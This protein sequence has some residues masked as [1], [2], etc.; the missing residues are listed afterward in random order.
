MR[1]VFSLVF[2]FFVL[3]CSAQVQINGVVDNGEKKIEGAVI[4]V[5]N[6]QQDIL[7]YNI[8]GKDGNFSIALNARAD[9]LLLVVSLLG[10]ETKA[11][12]V[13]YKNQFLQV[14]LEPKSIELKEVSIKS[15][16]IWKREDTLVYSVDAFKY[17]Q[18]R[19]IGDILKKLPG[20]EVSTSG[21]IKYNGEAINKFYIE[22]LDLL[23][24][25][26]GIATNNVP[27]DAVQNIEVIENHQPVN[28]LKNIFDTGQA[29]INLKLKNSKMVHPVGTVEAGIGTDQ[30]G[31]LWLF[32]AFALQ[33]GKK[34]QTIVMYKTNNAAI[35]IAGEM[36]GHSTD[37]SSIDKTSVKQIFS[38]SSFSEMSL[39][40]KRYLF[41]NTHVATINNVWKVS[42][43]EQ[44]RVNINYMHNERNENVYKRNTYYINS[45]SLFVIDESSRLNRVSNILDGAFTY[46]NNSDKFYLDDRLNTRLLWNKTVSDISSFNRITEHYSTPVYELSN[47][48]QFIKRNNTRIWDITSNIYYSSLPQRLAVTVD[49]LS[50]ELLQPVHYTGL[51]TNNSTYISFSKG[52]SNLL[53]R[54]R[55]EGLFEGLGSDLTHNYLTDSI[56]N[57]LK[58]DFV[59]LALDPEYTFRKDRIKLMFNAGIKQQWLG[60]KDRQYGK[61]KFFS[62][63]YILPRIN[64]NYKFNPFLEGIISYRF[65]K[66]IGD[67]FDFT[68]SVIMY[69]YRNI[70]IKSGI[71]SKRENQSFNIRI[72]YRNPINRL[73]FNT[74]VGYMHTKRNLLGKQSFVDIQSV[75]GNVEGNNSLDTWLWMLYAGKYAS[76]IRT[77]FSI[78]SNY[79]YSQSEKVQQGIRYPVRSY[80]LQ[81]SPMFNTKLSENMNVAYQFD[82]NTNKIKIVSKTGI[83]ESESNQLSHTLKY[84][85]FIKK[86]ELNIQLEHLYNKISKDI[87]TNTFFADI[88]IKLATKKVDFLLAWNN[89]FNKKEY[90]YIVYSSLDSYIYNFP[91]RPSNIL[92]T[93]AFK[94]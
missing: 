92:V 35:N 68:S 4:S 18:D 84:F 52:Y 94:Y 30:D 33:A 67:I 73:F 22:G 50:N 58:S 2:C 57:D 61:N 15:D 14:Q 88:N 19:T 82:F 24:N 90:K 91:L 41:N 54:F 69:N 65:N 37:L 7:D 9:S 47:K 49:T 72:N 10:Y 70:G 51:Y 31:L 8:S 25:K 26:Y 16:M 21:A 81:I 12:P 6:G 48:L 78:Q 71:L 66:S 46:N 55:M 53:V 34:R 38:E 93:I 28:S 20:I 45:D 74:S 36:V 80:M 77:N 64:I 87:S 56:R 11:I 59:I 60:I 29:A 42:E 83:S 23:E 5:I 39:N 79:T 76:D 75:S 40:S 86:W 43:S 32:N 85:Y 89:I 44:F 17:Q 62:Y 1:Y 27:A 63:L 3:F 13:D